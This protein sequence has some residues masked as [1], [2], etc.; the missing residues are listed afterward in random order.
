MIAE[1]KIKQ[2]DWAGILVA[3]QLVLG[4]FG[5]ILFEYPEETWFDTLATEGVFEEI[6]FAEEQPDVQAGMALLQEWAER[7]KDGLSDEEF[8]LVRDDYTRLLVGP[9]KVL[10]PPWESVYLKKERIIFQEETLLVREWYRRFGLESVKL[11]HE[12]DDHIGLELA[13]VANLA[14]KAFAAFEE[15]S[16][17]FTSLLEAQQQFLTEHTFVWASSWVDLMIENTK[18]D[19]FNGLALTVKGV[20]KELASIFNSD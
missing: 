8:G 6:P 13:F 20:L 19:F 3:E 15:G 17:E 7:N 2:Q 10:A 11:H 5:R 1:K 18:T 12:P 9:G 16:D 14:G 4:L